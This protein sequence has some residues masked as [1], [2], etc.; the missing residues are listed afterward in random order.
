MEPTGCACVVL[1]VSWAAGGCT[2]NGCG[3]GLLLDDSE[4]PGCADTPEPPATPGEI[5]ALGEVDDLLASARSWAT[6]ASAW[7]FSLVGIGR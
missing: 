5:D 2:L 4:P 6:T 7:F 3:L 1:L